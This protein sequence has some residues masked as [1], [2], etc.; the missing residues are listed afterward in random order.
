MQE[1]TV[2]DSFE[3]RRH[4][5]DYF[6]RFRWVCPILQSNF[7]L[8]GEARNLGCHP[9]CKAQDSFLHFIYPG[10]PEALPRPTIPG[11]NRLICQLSITAYMSPMARVI[12]IGI[13]HSILVKISESR[14]LT[15]FQEPYHT[16]HMINRNCLWEFPL[17]MRLEYSLSMLL[18]GAT[19]FH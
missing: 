15:F 5:F 14:N 8:G 2:H 10:F 4:F 19:C 6:C 16:F 11:L 18:N 3:S 7:D 12:D 9:I 17:L 13:M 1:S